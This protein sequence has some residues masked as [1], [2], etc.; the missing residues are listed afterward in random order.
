[1]KNQ[2]TPLSVLITGATGAIGSALAN[3]YAAP[4]VTLLLHGRN[5]VQ[6]EAVAAS[7]REQGATVITETL[8]VA[9]TQA[10]IGWVQQACAT[11]QLDLVIANAGMNTDI[12]PEGQGED[13]ATVE[14][15]IDVNIKGAM[16]TVAAAIPAM[17]ARG[18]GQLVLV[19]SL[20]AYFG[21]P[22]TPSY[23]ASKAALKA[24]GEGLRGWLASTGVKVNVVMPGYV[25]SPM[26]FEMPG[27]KPFLWQPERAA[28]YIRKHL[29]RN[30]PRISFP[31][32]L[33]FGC[34][35]LAVLPAKSAQRILGWMGYGV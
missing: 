22:V 35:W 5:A 2:S 11:Y 6:L 15:L 1:M 20:A 18:Q 33:N 32:P 4:G 17:R 24:Y 19:S 9:D 34:W 30:K 29:A 8:D 14:R 31:F 13:W 23:S 25:A 7:C 12:G 10:V 28:R 3:E 21:L 27:P 26:C 16:A